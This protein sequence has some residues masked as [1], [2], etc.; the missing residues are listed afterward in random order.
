MLPEALAGLSS[1]DFGEVAPGKDWLMSSEQTPAPRAAGPDIGLH[2][3]DQLPE[4]QELGG[5]G[6]KEA[7]GR[8]EP[9]VPFCN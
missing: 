4:L 1:S 8:L 3:E 6:A 2:F 5:R 9:P 7:S